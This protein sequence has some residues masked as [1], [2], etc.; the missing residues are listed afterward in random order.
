MSAANNSELENA[1]DRALVDFKDGL[2]R[3]NAPLSVVREFLTHG[4]CV[5]IDRATHAS[6]REVVA[7]ALGVH[8]NRDVYT[9]GSAKLGFSIKPKSRYRHF[10]D[11]SDVDIAVVSPEIYT[12]LWRQVRSFQSDKGIWKADQERMFKLRH[13]WGSIHLSDLPRSPLIPTQ[14]KLW[15]LGR[16]L[17]RSRAAGPYP[18]TFAI[19]N[20]MES[21]ENYQCRAVAACQET[22]QL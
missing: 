22:S 8:P 9:V 11:T 3:H 19:W 15:E 5:A 20:E 17:Q 7:G 21:L 1:I 4:P 6:L 12:S 16:T 2:K 18:V 10:S 13:F 14:E